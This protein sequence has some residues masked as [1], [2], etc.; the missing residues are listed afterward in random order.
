MDNDLRN[1]CLNVKDF[2]ERKWSP[3]NPDLS[4]AS[5]NEFIS[6]LN[7][8]P[9]IDVNFRETKAYNVDEPDINE[10]YLTYSS[11]MLRSSLNTD[12][13][14]VYT[15][16]DILMTQLDEYIQLID[17]GEE[18]IQDSEN[19]TWLNICLQNIVAVYNVANAAVGGR[20]RK[21]RKKRLTKKSRK[22]GKK[23]RKH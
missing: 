5:K 23:S 8:F 21:S 19:T 10:G 6:M 9:Y 4:L 13:A 17:D 14:I 20:K 18:D 12:A 1:F 3:P 7:D 22:S 16:R 2:L 15:L 11:Q